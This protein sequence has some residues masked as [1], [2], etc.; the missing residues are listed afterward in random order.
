VFKHLGHYL[1]FIAQHKILH[2]FLRFKVQLIKFSLPDPDHFHHYHP[3]L[4]SLIVVRF[5][6]PIVFDL[7]L[8]TN[9]NSLNK[10]YNETNNLYL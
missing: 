7:V 9:I 8:A 5:F 4:L 1:Y 6:D 10:L 2:Y 3:V